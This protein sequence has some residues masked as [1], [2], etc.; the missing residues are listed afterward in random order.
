V[1]GRAEGEGFLDVEAAVKTHFTWNYETRNE[2]VRRLYEK[3]KAG[4]WDVAGLD[5]TRML[6]F[7]CPLRA[8]DGAGADLPRPA[9][10]PV[11]ESRWNDFRWEYHAWL[12]S[13]FLHG[14]QGALL[15]TSRLV[16]VTPSIEDKLFAAIQVTDEARH[17][18]AYSAYLTRLGIDRSYPINDELRTLLAQLLAENRWDIV[19]L[20]MQVIV[21]G[22]ALALFRLGHISSFD[23]VVKEITRLVARD[24]ARHVS[25]GTVV[26]QD[27]YGE[28]TSAERADREEFVQE[29]ILLMSRRFR[30]SEV[31]DRMDVD[32][33]LGTEF[34]T[35]SPVM[36]DTRRLMFAK[37]ATCISR[38]GLLT[39]AV[40]EQ[41]STA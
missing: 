21:E 12:T 13:Q 3:A 35:R 6:E 16:E 31:W 38:I 8:A 1:V 18:E 24:E 7:G 2:K 27:L 15:A 41:L 29:S 33:S 5:W 11:P 23:P 37:V 26:L 34:A 32:R 19:F 4:Q 36:A 17:V 39:P 40:R 30:L 25:F 9:D 14:E 28:L 22:I 20:G 10:A